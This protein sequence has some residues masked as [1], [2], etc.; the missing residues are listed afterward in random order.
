MTA[1]R[2][3]LLNATVHY[4]YFMLQARV[5]RGPEG[6]KLTGVLENLG[7]GEKRPFDGSDAVVRMIE[8][9]G[10]RRADGAIQTSG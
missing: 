4:S 10:R 3:P 2:E 5:T 1:S 9:W 8:D 6:I 7:T